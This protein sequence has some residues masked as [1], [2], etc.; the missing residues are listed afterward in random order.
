V[1]S[2]AAVSVAVFVLFILLPSLGAQVI[3]GEGWYSSDPAGLALE[4]ILDPAGYEY[5]L[6]VRKQDAAVSSELFHDGE[7]V[8]TWI[9]TYGSNGFLSRE[10]V[11][12][13][14]LL[15]EE[16]VYDV[17]GRPSMER[18]FLDNGAIDE[19]AYEYDSGR[20][21]SRTTTTG[22]ATVLKR[23]YLYAPD[24][25]LALARE[26]SGS[27][28]GTSA[29]R[30]GG[31]SS[32]RIGEAGLELRSYDA[33]GRLVF[34]SIYDGTDRL[35]QEDHVWK[36]GT[37][38]RV[39]VVLAGG[40]TTSTEYVVSGPA[41]GKIAAITVTNSDKSV[42]KEQ[43]SYNGKGQLASVEMYLR[44]RESVVTYGYGDNDILAS[45]TTSVE[46]VLVSVVRHETPT[47]RVEELYDSG[48]VFARVRYEDG[49]RVL[50]EM[51]RDGVVTRTRRFP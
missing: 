34:I 17:Q 29:A 35:S 8:K 11:E 46:G 4:S 36:D 19:T 41:R 32:W 45:T 5:T 51:L 47:V 23:T 14:G 43:R 48:A 27:E 3:P 24:G 44:G 37:L 2:R 20:L 28:S 42:S 6:R 30:S 26:E 12:K 22:G 9:R 40:S 31:S 10:A 50:E 38:E 39:T 16:F 25:R 7:A 1:N 33:T 21:V 15:K 13:D 49:R 18:I